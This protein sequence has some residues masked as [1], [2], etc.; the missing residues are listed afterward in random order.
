[1]LRQLIDFTFQNESF[2]QDEVRL[3]KALVE[4][5]LD[6]KELLRTL[7]WDS[8]R[9]QT[10]SL[11]VIQKCGVFSLSQIPCAILQK[12][13]E[14][15]EKMKHFVKIPNVLILDDES[16]IVEIVAAEFRN[17]G[18]AIFPYSKPSD[19]LI[20]NVV[21]TQ[22]DLILCDI[23]LGRKT[24]FELI[25]QIRERFGFTP[26]TVL[27]TADD[28]VTEEQCRQYGAY[29]VHKPFSMGH[30]VS[31]AIEAF[32][33]GPT[34]LPGARRMART[35]YS[36]PCLVNGTLQCTTDNISGGGMF[37]RTKEAAQFKVQDEVGF[38]LDILDLGRVRGK[39]IIRWVNPKTKG[40]M[41][42][43]LGIEFKDM[44][45]DVQNHLLNM[46]VS[47]TV[48]SLVSFKS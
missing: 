25:T 34:T 32:L 43:G 29:L 46:A 18:C 30:L 31:T 35:Y 8:T 19:E 1:M 15:L 45:Q 28:T 3:L 11:G 7:G 5:H 12:S 6:E 2:S 39:G 20:S 40:L 21:E 47:K 4:G 41:P 24:A 9:F 38:D 22:I 26:A 33:K 36:A 16:E 23:H 48:L 27:M 42:A 14:T 13:V 44:P 10:C 17:R 37:I